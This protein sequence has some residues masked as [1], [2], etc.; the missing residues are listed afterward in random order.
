MSQ[1]QDNETIDVLRAAA[2]LG[3]EKRR[4]YDITNALMGANVLKKEGKSHYKW[5]Y[6]FTPHFTP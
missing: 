4:I 1:S 3:V 2:L 6:S 5:M